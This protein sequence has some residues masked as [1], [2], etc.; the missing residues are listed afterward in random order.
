MSRKTNIS[1]HLT[2]QMVL[3][4]RSKRDTRKSLNTRT[5]EFTSVLSLEALHWGKH[6]ESMVRDGL[7]HVVATTTSNQLTDC[8]VAIPPLDSLAQAF[9]VTVCYSSMAET[10]DPCE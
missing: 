9:P 7:W 8:V 4:I 2:I 10:A 1:E 5:L 6:A 3:T